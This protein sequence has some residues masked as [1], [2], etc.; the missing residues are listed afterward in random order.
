LLQGTERQNQVSSQHA[1]NPNESSDNNND[2][3]S[4]EAEANETM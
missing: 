2:I 4:I 1:A 3:D